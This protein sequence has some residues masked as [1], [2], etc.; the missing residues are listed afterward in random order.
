MRPLGAACSVGWASSSK[1]ATADDSR[2]Q[3]RPVSMKPF[4]PP[5][6]WS[7]G[8]SARPEMMEEAKIMPAVISPRSTSAAP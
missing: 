1:G 8:W 6:I 7:I 2:V 3:A 4:H 5:M